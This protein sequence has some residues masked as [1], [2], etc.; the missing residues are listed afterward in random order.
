[1]LRWL[2]RLTFPKALALAVVWPLTLLILGVMAVAWFLFGEAQP[3]GDVIVSF[4][5]DGA[6]IPLLLWGPPALV[7]AAW[8]VARRRYRSA[9]ERGVEPTA[10]TSGLVE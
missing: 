3:E 4:S 1:M 8:G 5:A 9:T 6:L 2:A 10:P 7:F